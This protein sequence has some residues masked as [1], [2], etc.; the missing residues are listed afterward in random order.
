MDD[1]PEQ[2]EPCPAAFDYLASVLM[3]WPVIPPMEEW[4]LLGIDAMTGLKRCFSLPQAL[5][6]CISKGYP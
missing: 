6:I 5:G 4:R 3:A 2:P 1:A